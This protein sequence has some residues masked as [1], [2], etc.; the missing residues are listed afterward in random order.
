MSGNPAYGITESKIDY[1]TTLIIINII[2]SGVSANPAYGINNGEGN[3]EYGSI[4][5]SDN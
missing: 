4:G 1:K 5:M 3:T 2:G